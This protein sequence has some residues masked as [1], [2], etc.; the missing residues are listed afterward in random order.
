FRLSDKVGLYAYGGPRGDP[1]LG[2]TAYPPRASVS[3]NVLAIRGHHEQDATH[4]SNSV[5]TLG[6]DPGPVQL[7]ASPFHGPGPEANRWNIEGGAPAWFA[8]RLT[9]AA[10]NN[11]VGQFSIGRLNSREALDPDVDTIRTTASLE[12][13]VTFGSGHVSSSLIWGR[14]KDITHHG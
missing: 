8:T 13:N 5:I 12:H 2:P 9:L 4:I 3:E 14:N 6:F 1:A 10:G 11:L 7:A